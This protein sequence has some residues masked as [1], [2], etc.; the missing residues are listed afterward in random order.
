[1]HAAVM[2]TIKHYDVHAVVASCN[3]DRAVHRWGCTSGDAAA[4][5]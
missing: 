2:Y 5:A 1:M 3:D 4:D